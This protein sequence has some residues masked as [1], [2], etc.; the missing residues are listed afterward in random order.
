MAPDP[1]AEAGGARRR[2]TLER[3]FRASIEDVWDLWTTQDGIES[4]WGPDGFVVQVRE[5]DLRPGGALAYAMIAVA[6]DQIEFLRKAGM[7]LAN[8]HRLTY[9]E[10][11]PRRRLAY[12]HLADFVPGVPPY[13]VATSVEFDAGPRG[14]RMVLSFDAMHDDHW[15]RLAVMGW[16]SQLGKLAHV[17]RG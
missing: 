3:T 5:L 11:A 2:I 13:E 1:S 12:V 15:T 7:P 4:W 14:V 16:E 10:V 9:T 6:R 8:E 17:L